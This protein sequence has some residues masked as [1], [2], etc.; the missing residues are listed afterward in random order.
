MKLFLN[1]QMHVLVIWEEI[2]NVCVQ[3]LL[4]MLTHVLKRES[5]FDGEHLT[6]VVSQANIQGVE[7]FNYKNF[8]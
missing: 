1:I 7:T 3:L 6:C 4:L 8:S 5:I 2:V